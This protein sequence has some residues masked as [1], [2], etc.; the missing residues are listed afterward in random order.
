MID[1]FPVL[2]LV[3]GG[4]AVALRPRGADW[5]ADEMRGLRASGYSVLVST[6]Q[7]AEA[8]EF[9]LEL[10]GEL[11][12]SN[13]IEFI[14]APIPDRGLPEMANALELAAHL[15]A[16]VAQGKRVAVHCRQGIGRSSLTVATVLVAQ[17]DAPDVAWSRIA[18][19][20]GRPV[21]DTDDQRFWLHDFAARVG[22]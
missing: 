14:A 16:A 17:G 7:A 15:V 1:L 21:P 22:R 12:A 20:R 18:A 10:E 5:L 13:G 19:A 3:D 9:E 6:L 11:A 8:S 4:I 2:G